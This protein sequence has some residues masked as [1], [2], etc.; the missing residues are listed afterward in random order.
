MNLQV[1]FNSEDRADP[2]RTVG[3]PTITLAEE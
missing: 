1:R 3:V 2:S